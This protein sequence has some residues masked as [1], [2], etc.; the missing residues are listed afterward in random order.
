MLYWLIPL[1]VILFFCLISLI[2]SLVAFFYAFYAP[3]PASDEEN[4][5][6]IPPGEEYLPY[7]ARMSEW[8]VKA[9]A[10][11]CMEVEVVSFDG[12]K[13]CGKYYEY[14]NGAPIEIMFH[15]YRGSA[16]RD[17]SGG[18]DRAFR[19]G[20]NALIVD[21]RA[22]GKSEGRVITFGKKE[23]RDV[24]SWIDF[25]LENIDENAKIILTG[26]SM[27]A[28][29]VLM[30]TSQKLPENVLY[31]LADCGYSGSEKII[32]KVM[33]QMHLPIGPVYPFVALAARIFG[34]FTLDEPS[35]AEAM[36]KCKIPVIFF[37]G[38]ADAFVPM[39]MSEE[40]Y[41]AC[42]AEHKRLVIIDGAPHGACF[43]HNEELYINEIVEF[44]KKIGCRSRS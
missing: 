9:R 26:I 29:T 12:L 33:R 11:E 30:S 23:S 34:G 32:K 37:H 25:V 39:E 24:L 7:T 21:H 41:E 13:L 42:A 28:A 2:V 1:T 14:K 3:R 22:A 6:P 43:P 16:Q 40:N 5:I 31:V 10:L 38:N 36:E 4:E 35:P 44:E 8:V 27:G 20:H 15:G 17:L 19:V 18:V